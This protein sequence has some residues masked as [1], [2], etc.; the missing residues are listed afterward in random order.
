M[1]QMYGVVFMYMLSRKKFNDRLIYYHAR[2]KRCYYKKLK[3]EKLKNLRRK[4]RS[5]WVEK[6]R[7]ELMNGG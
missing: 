6:G 1:Y 3:M 5:K 4:Q 7:T 2:K